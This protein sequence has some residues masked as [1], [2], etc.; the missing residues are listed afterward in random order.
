MLEAGLEVLPQPKRVQKHRH[1]LSISGGQPCSCKVATSCS[2]GSVLRNLHWS[3]HT[4]VSSRTRTSF[5]VV[6]DCHAHKTARAM[7]GAT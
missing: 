5:Q 4:A 7:R 2:C 1:M 6:G 3:A